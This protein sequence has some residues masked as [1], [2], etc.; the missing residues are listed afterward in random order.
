[1]DITLDISSYANGAVTGAYT[2]HSACGSL[3]R[4][5]AAEGALRFV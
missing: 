2:P 4:V 3:D 5:L 1:M